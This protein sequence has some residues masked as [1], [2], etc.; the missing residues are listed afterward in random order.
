M[1]FVLLALSL[2]CVTS[3]TVSA[4]MIDQ[5][6]IISLSR[7][8]SDRV[9]AARS[10]FERRMYQIKRTTLG[11]VGVIGMG[12]LFKYRK[13]LW[14][15]YAGVSAEDKKKNEEFEK[16]HTRVLAASDRLAGAEDRKSVV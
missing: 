1:K 8:S 14:R 5:P 13:N 6:T 11:V 15:A 9:A 4:G 12:I 16:L 10:H 3:A 7:F 2:F